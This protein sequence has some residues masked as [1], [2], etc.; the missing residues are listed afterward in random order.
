MKPYDYRG[1][2]FVVFTIEGSG[3]GNNHSQFL[4]VF[5]V[6]LA[7]HEP[8][9]YR[10]LDV[11]HIG[12]KGRRTIE[13]LDAKSIKSAGKSVGVSFDL[14]ALEIGPDDGPSSPSVKT[15]IHMVFKENRLWEVAPGTPSG[16]K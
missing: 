14:E 9:L 4:A 6:A 12:E 13:K 1:L 3:R 7:D 5:D 11:R 10:F 15:T 8:A 16:L 2:A